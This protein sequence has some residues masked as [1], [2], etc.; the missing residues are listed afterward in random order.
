MLV[1]ERETKSR[2]VPVRR[3]FVSTYLTIPCAGVRE[4]SSRNTGVFD[5]DRYVCVCTC[6]YGADDG[7]EELVMSA[8]ITSLLVFEGEH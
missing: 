6:L 8:I 4:E 7:N 5:A 2:T 1:R 3:R